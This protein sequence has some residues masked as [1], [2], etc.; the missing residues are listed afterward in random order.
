MKAL[1]SSFREG[2]V[3]HNSLSVSL[4]RCLF[5]SNYKYEHLQVIPHKIHFTLIMNCF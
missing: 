1:G 5:G 3:E 4:N 2:E